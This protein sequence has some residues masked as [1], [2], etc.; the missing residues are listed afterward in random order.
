MSTWLKFLFWRQIFMGEK[1]MKAILRKL[2]NLTS[3][4]R[5]VS[6]EVFEPVTAE[7]LAKR[8]THTAGQ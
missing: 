3:S 8:Q 4:M 2:R 7:L 1:R 6:H 5:G